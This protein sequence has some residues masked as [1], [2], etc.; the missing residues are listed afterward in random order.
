MR[1]TR[2]QLNIIWNALLGY[3]ENCIPPNDIDYDEQW[4]EIC[5]VMANIENKLD[6]EENV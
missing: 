5:T 1:L 6:I 2:H 3:R 4:G